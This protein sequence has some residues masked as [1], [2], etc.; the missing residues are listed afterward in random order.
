M[1]YREEFQFNYNSYKESLLSGRYITLKNIQPILDRLTSDFIVSEIGYSVLGKPIHSIRFGYGPKKIFMWSQMHGNESTTT[2][3]VFDVINYLQKK[4]EIRNHILSTFTICV[5]PLLNPDG[6]EAYTR[7]NSNE[8]DLNRDAQQLSQPESKVLRAE[9]NEFKPHFCFNLHDQ[10][11]IFSAGNHKKSATVSFLTPAEDKE[12][13]VTANRKRSME[14]I[15]AMNKM[16]QEHIPNQVGRYDDGFNLNCV[17]DTFQSEGV[18]T[19]LFESGHFPSDYEREETRRLIAFSILE[20]IMYIGE[21]EVTGEK[22]HDY[23]KIP[24]NEKLFYDVIL[25]GFPVKSKE[26]IE[27]KDVAI[28][29]KESLNNGKIEFKPTVEHVEDE[30]KFFG[31]KELSVNDLDVEAIE[32]HE[33]NTSYLTE[34]LKKI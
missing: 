25:R 3:A 24:E 32:V 30:L 11:T 13:K 29:F 22:H 33:L 4:P 21:T 17:G 8:V 10:R 28:F 34:F 6:A 23:F 20:A 18:P 15:S 14:V 1:D 27:R 31:H 2:K 5:I 16:L 9:F 26:G 7:H 19:I 12:R